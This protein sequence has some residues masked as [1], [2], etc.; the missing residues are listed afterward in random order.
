MQAEK[1]CPGCGTR[2]HYNIAKV[3][4]VDEEEDAS[5]PPESQQPREPSTRK[6]PRT[7]A[8][9]DSDTV[10]PESSQSTRLTRRSVRLKSSG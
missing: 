9:I 6:R 8:A 4:A 1:V 5:A 2:W 3:E 10:E 7:R